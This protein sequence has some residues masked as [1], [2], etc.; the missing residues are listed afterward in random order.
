MKP[1]GSTEKEG[2]NGQHTSTGGRQMRTVL[3]T[4]HVIKLTLTAVILKKESFNVIQLLGP[5]LSK[6]LSDQ[7]LEFGHFHKSR[8]VA[9]AHKSFGVLDIHDQHVRH[10]AHHTND[11]LELRFQIHNPLNDGAKCLR[12]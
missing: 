12:R 11:V 1:R 10:I 6:N 3:P 4:H 5:E 7:L 8:Y 9:S 2:R